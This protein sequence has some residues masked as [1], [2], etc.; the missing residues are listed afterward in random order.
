MD[1]IQERKARQERAE[2]LS[3][4]ELKTVLRRMPQDDLKA[5]ASWS[6]AARLE[7]RRRFR[8][9]GEN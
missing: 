5:M 6:K 8:T 3:G 9:T 7:L 2:N 1:T 4:K